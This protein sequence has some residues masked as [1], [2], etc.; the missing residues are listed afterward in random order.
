MKAILASLLVVAALLG[1][2]GC[3][4]EEEAGSREEQRLSSPT[5]E[6]ALPTPSPTAEPDPYVTSPTPEPGGA[7]EVA[8]SEKPRDSTS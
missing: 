6:P 5:A 3:G 4:D 1:V 2:A 7:E 8:R